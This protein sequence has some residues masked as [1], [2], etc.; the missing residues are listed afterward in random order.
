MSRAALVDGTLVTRDDLWPWLAERAGAAT[1]EAVAL[2]R[3]VQREADRRGVTVSSADIQ[4]ERAIVERA[5]VGAGLD[6]RQQRGRVV[7]EARARR[8]WGPAWFEAL[9][10]RNAIARKLTSQGVK[11]PSEPEIARLYEALHGP[12]RR[13]RVLVMPN[14]R[15]LSRHRVDVL[16][17]LERSA[18]LGEARMIALAAEH[19][20]DVSSARGGLLDPVSRV[21]P[22]YP[23]AFRDAVFGA[24]V[25]ELTPVVAL[26]EGFAFAMVVGSD[27]GSGVPLEEARRDLV[28]RLELDAQQRAMAALYERLRNQMRIEPLDAALEWSWEATGR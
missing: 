21:D 19:S 28:E 14:E 10:R 9:L 17:Q 7:A 25:G 22:I 2:D 15:Q 3:A 20:S 27:P 6:E 4:A 26:D 16:S 1:L 8:G 18:E 13:V 5:L 23:D 24:G 12:R 11:A